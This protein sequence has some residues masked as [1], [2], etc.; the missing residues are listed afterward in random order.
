M[1]MATTQRQK[2]TSGGSVTGLSNAPS[3]GRHAS[4]AW[5]AIMSGFL[6]L[7]LACTW[8]CLPVWCAHHWMAFSGPPGWRI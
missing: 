8:S 3:P 2:T 7:W 5:C 6:L 4:D 1:A